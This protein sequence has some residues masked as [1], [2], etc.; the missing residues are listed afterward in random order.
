MIN[1]GYEI[2][3]HLKY[4]K[5]HCGDDWKIPQ[6]KTLMRRNSQIKQLTLIRVKSDFLQFVGITLPDL[7]HL[8]IVCFL[9]HN[10]GMDNFQFN[11]ERLKSLIVRGNTCERDFRIQSVISFVANAP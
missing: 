9:E 4:V 2:M 6:I 3:P 5:T 1:I 7:E 8:E 11:F 10:L